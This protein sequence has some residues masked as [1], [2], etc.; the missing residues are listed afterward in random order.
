MEILGLSD[1]LQMPLLLS[2]C[3]NTEKGAG[4]LKKYS[5]STITTDHQ[6]SVKNIQIDE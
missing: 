3:E 6:T 1:I 5:Q 2:I 4:Y